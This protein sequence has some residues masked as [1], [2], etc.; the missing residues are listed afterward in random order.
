MTE[1]EH[2]ALWAGLISSIVGIVLAVVA[3]V[4]S[5][6]GNVRLERVTD[7]TVKS[8]QKIESDV[9]RISEE[10]SG[11]IKAGWERM[12]GSVAGNGSPVLAATSAKEIA[13]GL[14]NEMR[15]AVKEEMKRSGEALPPDQSP[16]IE[17]VLK[18]IGRTI[19]AQMGV[20]TYGG[21]RSPQ[22]TWDQRIA[23]LPDLAREVA[24][25]IRNHHLTRE[26]YERLRE[27]SHIGNAVVRLRRV[28]LLVPL[29]DHGNQDSVV[30]WFP[31]DKVDDI[32][33]ALLLSRPRD[34]E[35]REAVAV[36]LARV[37]YGRCIG[38]SSG[39]PETKPQT[40]ADN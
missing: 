34:S 36:D 18:E 8:L 16:R 40:P 3:I 2:V 12:L 27:S 35:S 29:S 39:S 7:Q 11:L 10:T 38:C 22:L 37:G 28:G 32:K 9:Q 21:A 6:I 31:P 17:A 15:A 13:A 4:S 23:A 14:T 24:Y 26:Q 19:A 1:V 33:S 5:V 25:Q 30:Y 20:T